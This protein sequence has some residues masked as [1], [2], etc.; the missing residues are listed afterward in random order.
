MTYWQY[1]HSVFAWVSLTQLSRQIEGSLL[2]VTGA[3]ACSQTCQGTPCSP[4]SQARGMAL[5]K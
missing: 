5:G 1:P 2:F 3:R 4:S